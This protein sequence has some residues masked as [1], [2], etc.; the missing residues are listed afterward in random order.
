MA[1]TLVAHVTTDVTSSPATSSAI[2]TTGA[3]LI[4]VGVTV[5][6]A[7]ATNSITD[8]KANQWTALTA[9][10]GTGRN[11]LRMFYAKRPLVG[12]GHTF[13]DSAGSNGSMI[14][15]AFSGILVDP[16]DGQGTGSSGAGSTSLD[17]GLVSPI[18]DYELIVTCFTIDDPAGNTI[19][20]A[21]FTV[22]DTFDVVVGSTYG[23]SMAYQVQGVKTPVNPHWTRSNANTQLGDFG[24][25]ASFLSR[26]SMPPGA[27]VRHQQR[28]AA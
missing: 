16:F 6:G 1:V 28:R 10:S 3:G 12:A 17:A 4:V 19:A 2:D 8:N 25:V 27:A 20:C 18:H 22:I 15:S 7:P 14:V 9:A 23:L 5:G 11:G 24:A 21:G 13:T 26:Y